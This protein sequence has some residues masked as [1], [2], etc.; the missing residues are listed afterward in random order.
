MPPEMTLVLKP[1][2]ANVAIFQDRAKRRSSFLSMRLTVASSG[3]K[4]L[5]SHRIARRLGVS[6]LLSPE[7]RCRIVML[8]LP[9]RQLTTLWK[10]DG[11]RSERKAVLI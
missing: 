4:L 7:H 11:R 1:G 10:R 8:V 9:L 3:V 5:L 6:L 2:T